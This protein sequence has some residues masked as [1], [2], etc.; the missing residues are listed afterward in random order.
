MFKVI[1]VTNRKLCE[2]DFM[3]QVKRL[4]E[5]GISGII[6]REKDLP[7]QEY[8]ELALKVL[9]C[10]KEFSVPCILHSHIDV[11]KELGQYAIHMSFPSFL[12]QKEFCKEFR[13]GVSV[14]SA[15]EAKEAEKSGASYL[16][17]GH[18]FRTDCK[19]GL[20]PRG[21]TF[22]QEVAD[23]VSIPVYAIGGIHSGNI[24][25][26]KQTGCAGCCIM[27]GAMK[28]SREVLASYKDFS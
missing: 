23:A 16:V 24:E 12:K 19:K 9:E 18:I 6:L 2:V 11:A 20:A 8:K 15:E 21:L 26:V 14:H 28:G 7:P 10:L 27:S 3:E 5:A 4:G 17:A 25:K 1:A 22:L 13:T